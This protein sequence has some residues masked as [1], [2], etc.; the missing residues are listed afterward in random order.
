LSSYHL[1]IT[2]NSPVLHTN[3]IPIPRFPLKHLT[4]VPGYEGGLG[5]VGCAWGP[6]AFSMVRCQPFGE[7]ACAVGA[8]GYLDVK[9]GGD[10]ECA[11]VKE[12]VIPHPIPGRPSFIGKDLSGCSVS[13]GRRP[14]SFGA[15][16]LA[17]HR[18]V[19][20]VIRLFKNC[21]P[22]PTT[23]TFNLIG[24]SRSPTT[25]LK[26][27]MRSKGRIEIPMGWLP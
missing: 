9:V 11:S 4:D 17:L 26:T 18:Y 7:A 16:L 2:P 8:V 22:T 24:L 5:T 13:Y 25:D 6:Q 23:S 20:A 1:R 27:P 15:N 21:P 3:A 14:E 12:S 10:G 19:K